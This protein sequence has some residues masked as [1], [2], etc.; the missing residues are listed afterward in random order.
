LRSTSDHSSPCV[1]K[2]VDRSTVITC[3]AADDDGY[4]TVTTV[5]SYF[6]GSVKFKERTVEKVLELTTDE[7]REC[8]SVDLVTATA[9]V[10]FREASCLAPQQLV[11]G[12]IFNA[13]WGEITD[14]EGPLDY[15]V[16]AA[17][18]PGAEFVN[19]GR[20]AGTTELTFEG[21]LEAQLDP[22][23][24][25][26]DLVTLGLVMPTVTFSQTSCTVAGTYRLGAAAGYDPALLTFTVNGVAGIAAG[27][28][29][30]T[31]S[32]LVKVTAQAVGSNGLEFD[33]VDPPAF[34]FL[35]PGDSECDEF[36]DPDLPT[37][38]LPTLDLPTLAYTGGGGASPLWWLAPASLILLGAAAMYVRRRT[39]A[40]VS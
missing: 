38:A 40:D 22:F 9:M 18:D 8:G 2:E 16:T 10:S 23:S 17:A 35:A 14:P 27:T 4:A 37:L 32:G 1:T 11:S 3:P 19:G 25:E 7:I 13:A 33:W 5:H 15:S 39:D 29:R 28:Y 24:P 30:M 6:H 21:M 12:P 34:A 36:E 26:C 20:V 31:G